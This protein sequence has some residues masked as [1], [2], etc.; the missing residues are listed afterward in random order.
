[1]TSHFHYTLPPILLMLLLNQD[2]DLLADLSIAICSSYSSLSFLPVYCANYM[3][4][5]KV[6]SSSVFLNSLFRSPPFPGGGKQVGKQWPCTVS[7]GEG[8]SAQQ[9]NHTGEKSNREDCSP[10]QGNAEKLKCQCQWRILLT[11]PD[12]PGAR[13]S[14]ECISQL[15]I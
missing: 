14:G 13:T 4:I 10:K 3:C 12:G 8:C 11:I 1:M 2:Q 9:Q 15:S 5:P 6:Y 7:A